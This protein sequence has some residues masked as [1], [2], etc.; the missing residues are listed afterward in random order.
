MIYE[1]CQAH[2][3]LYKHF[4]ALRIELQ[5]ITGKKVSKEGYLGFKYGSYEMKNSSKLN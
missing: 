1:I 5:E 2:N 4:E 3:S